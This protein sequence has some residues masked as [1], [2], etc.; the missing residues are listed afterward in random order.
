MSAALDKLRAKR[1]ALDEK[2]K[3]MEKAEREAGR[4]RAIKVLESSGLLDL[5]EQELL[6][7]LA[8]IRG[9]TQ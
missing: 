5:P 8:A 7:K 6:A 1:K 4:E 9:G 2:I 3:A